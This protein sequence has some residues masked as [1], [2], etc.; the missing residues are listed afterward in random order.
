[1]SF[2]AFCGSRWPTNLQHIVCFRNK[3]V[4]FWCSMCLPP[5]FHPNDFPDENFP[6][7]RRAETL[8]THACDLLRL[9]LCLLRETNQ[10][11]ITSYML[12]L[13][14][15]IK[16]SSL[17]HASKIFIFRFNQLI[18]DHV[19]NCDCCGEPHQ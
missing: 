4:Y 18:L 17:S 7:L 16:N 13:N 5:L 3:M 19:I 10:G 8:S 1:M 2:D 6:Y 11:S 12:I 15:V 14:I 9:G